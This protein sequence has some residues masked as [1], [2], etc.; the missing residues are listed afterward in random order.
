MTYTPPVKQWRLLILGVVTISLVACSVSS[1]EAHQPETATTLNLPT[2]SPTLEGSSTREF[3]PPDITPTPDNPL[4]GD[5]PWTV[6]IPSADGV[7]L[8]ATVY[9]QGVQNLVLAP[10]YPG[11]QEGWQAFAE[12]AAAQGYRTISFD[13]KGYGKSGGTRLSADAPRDL[14]SVIGFSRQHG[15]EQIV[16]MGAGFGGLAAIRVAAH[17]Q[18]IAGLVVISAPRSYDGL[19]VGDSELSS[20][21]LPSLW[22]GARNDMLQDIE[23]LYEQVTGGDKELWIYEG[24]SLQ[25]TY[26]FEGA[27]GLDMEQRLLAFAA[28]ALS[29]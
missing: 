19:E 4:V 20:L 9:G 13:F 22:L 17:D 5:G 16:L 6:A 3:D 28:R 11:G 18:G 23:S 14:E 26:I 8:D 2:A 24:S 27:D 15:A 1:S 7:S 29:P 25:G 12:L 21:L 10:M